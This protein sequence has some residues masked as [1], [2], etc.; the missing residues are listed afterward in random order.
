MAKLIFTS[1]DAGFTFHLTAGPQWSV[2]G[3]S[4]PDHLVI[5]PGVQAH[6]SLGSAGGDTV[7]FLGSPADY[8]V[9][10]TGSQAVL[11]HTSS[12]HAVFL[13]ASGEA[14]Q[15]I[16]DPDPEIS[17]DEVLF[18]LVITAQG[19][20]LGQ[21]QLTTTPTKLGDSLPDQPGLSLF[22]KATEQ[23]VRNPALDPL[24]SY[25]APEVGWLVNRS[26]NFWEQMQLSYGFPSTMPVEYGADYKLSAGWQPASSTLQDIVHESIAY[27]SSIIGLD[28]IYE[29]DGDAADIRLSVNQQQETS[30]FA[31]FPGPG[32]GGDIFISKACDLDTDIKPLDYVK[33]VVLHEL[34]HALGLKHPFE[35]PGIAPT[36]Y[37]STMY[38]IMSYTSSPYII[39]DFY[40]FGDMWSYN[41]GMEVLPAHASTYSLLDIA[42]LQALYGYSLDSVADNTYSFPAPDHDTW[43]YIC[44]WDAGG[45]DTLD[46][47]SLSV[48]VDFDMRPG[49]FSTIG[50]I[51]VEE[52]IASTKQWFYTQVQQDHSDWIEDVY[53]LN[54]INNIYTGRDNFS[55]AFGT[56]IENIKTGSGNDF[57][58]DNTVD[59]YIQTGQGNDYIVV[60]QGGFDYIDGG[61]GLDTV[62]VPVAA[63]QCVQGWEGNY[64]FCIADTFA[65]C[66]IG[67]EQIQFTDQLVYVV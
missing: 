54:G 20:L 57:I 16:F 25:W 39:P 2:V 1:Q 26:I 43:A 29:P 55:L 9:S 42:A 10:R 46:F 52:Q 23:S 44:L 62:N 59:N 41:Y 24:V 34:G 3:S 64:Y 45:T 48:P 65:L 27:L 21:Q 36:A 49:S 51:S 6:L 50:Y 28:F 60:G 40:I 15:I 61:P 19:V 47:S 31:Y 11:T 7:R 67:V 37:D 5:A 35:G 66:L 53:H 58:I 22:N 13:A 63:D 38:S 17:G 8:L 32:V 30:G 4:L 33:E 56:V 14:D 12:G 18:D